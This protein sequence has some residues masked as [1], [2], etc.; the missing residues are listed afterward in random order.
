MFQLPKIWKKYVV[1]IKT[2]YLKMPDTFKND[3]NFMFSFEKVSFR[4][5]VVWANATATQ[6]FAAKG[7]IY[8]HL[9]L[10]SSKVQDALRK[11]AHI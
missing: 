10:I 3:I 5:K 11:M 1:P 8:M 6:R 4:I 7:T 2:F 9:L